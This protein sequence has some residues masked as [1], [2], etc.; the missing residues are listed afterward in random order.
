MHASQ[1][2]KEQIIL[3]LRKICDWHR[4]DFSSI[5]LHK[6][7]PELK[8]Y[9]SAL[10]IEHTPE[11]IGQFARSM[12]M[13]TEDL[14]LGFDGPDNQRAEFSLRKM[15]T[16]KIREL[17]MELGGYLYI[18]GRLEVLREGDGFLREVHLAE[19][20]G[21][22]QAGEYDNND[23]YVP[24]ELIARLRLKNGDIVAGTRRWPYV[25]E[26]H[27]VLLEAQDVTHVPLVHEKANKSASQ[28]KA[29]TSAD[30][31]VVMPQLGEWQLEG[32]IAKWLKK[33]GDPVE[34]NETL[35]EITTDKVDAE[36]PAPT[37][38]ILTEI[39]IAEG[40]T[41]AVNTVVA[42]IGGLIMAPEKP[43]SRLLQQIG[44][45]EEANTRQKGPC[46][47]CVYF[48]NGHSVVRPAFDALLGSLK[49]QLQMA[50]TQK[51]HE[52]RQ[53]S[54]LAFVELESN[55]QQERIDYT[56][57][58]TVPQ[59]HYCGLDEFKGS[60]YLCEVKNL[61]EQCGDFSKKGS[62]WNAHS[63]RTCMWHRQ[64][65]ASLVQVIENIT[66]GRP[67]G[68]PVRDQIRQSLQHQAET[69]F[70]A[71]IEGAGIVPVFPGLLPIC[72]V[73]TNSSRFDDAVPHFVVGP[74]ANAGEACDRW[75]AGKLVNLEVESVMND[76]VT[77]SM[78][79]IDAVKE[80]T[81]PSVMDDNILAS[82]TMR[83]GAAGNAQADVI[84]HCLNALKVD[85]AFVESMCRQFTLDVWFSERKKGDWRKE[86]SYSSGSTAQSPQATNATPG[87]QTAEGF[88]V[89]VN[90][91][92][93]HSRVEDLHFV[94]YQYPPYFT[95]QVN[96]IQA[97]KQDLF[98]LSQFQ[99][100]TWI[101]LIGQRGPIPIALAITGPP[102]NQFYGKWL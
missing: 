54:D 38:G 48:R 61:D 84:E 76:L 43:E 36:I 13:R 74:V 45:N 47:E 64:P 22:S 21:L 86:A 51:L 15:L 77:L 58:P 37:A 79:A 94:I 85:P 40:Q 23:V 44:S 78:R 81:S 9:A 24:S 4:D 68:Q 28:S 97:G 2:Q 93:R 99:P 3:E 7:T 102:L 62:D 71:C 29:Q 52:E 5:M 12:R 32:T 90:T 11:A 63:C 75:F 101:H 35:F 88:P 39:R 42:V 19:D 91:T 98:D 65:E 17:I 1:Q 59:I 8:K 26:Q 95:A 18:Q 83:Q 67:K 31:E 57:R 27:L 6:T 66:G 60:F 69:E 16:Q 70:E 53:S 49:S 92:Y 87:T 56:R 25:G 34:K 20:W 10:A 96:Y 14:A 82:T 50:Y 73:Y 30:T 55:I 80:Y 72:E 33:T 41:V 100:K 46:T 89:T